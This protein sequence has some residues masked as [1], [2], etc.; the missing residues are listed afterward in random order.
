MEQRSQSTD[1]H[2]RRRERVHPQDQAS[3][4][5]VVVGFKATRPHFFRSGHYRLE[6][7]LERNRF[8]SIERA[9]NRLSIGRDLL[10]GFGAIEV[11]AAG[12]EP[13]FGGC[14]FRDHLK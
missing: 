2:F 9:G 3:A 10:Q 13:D 11:L 12:N 8:G 4:V 5:V 7:D 6:D 1:P 14:E